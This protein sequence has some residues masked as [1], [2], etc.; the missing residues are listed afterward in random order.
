MRKMTPLLLALALGSSCPAA[1]AAPVLDEARKEIRSELEQAR[2]ELAEG[3]L[4]LGQGISLGRDKARAGREHQDLPPAVI[5]RDGRL[6]IDGREV[7]ATAAQRQLLLDYRASVVEV[8]RAGID[9]G[10]RAALLTMDAID[11]SMLSLLASAM[12]G[13][14]ERKVQ[15]TVMRE[16]GPLAE[17]V[18]GR[19]PAALAAQQRL[20]DAMAPFR[21]YANL[22]AD[23][24]HTCR[25]DIARSLANR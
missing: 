20:A 21:P 17:E 18:C 24:V 2:R 7:A 6:H 22:D 11:S 25:Q 9:V 15:A 19:L 3:D 12:T 16:L 14:L 4:S 5:T 13:S 8:A 1:F 10:E 23:D